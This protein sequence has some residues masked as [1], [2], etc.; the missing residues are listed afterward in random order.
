MSNL[1]S[2]YPVMLLAVNGTITK[3][4]TRSLYVIFIPDFLYRRSKTWEVT[5]TSG[6]FIGSPQQSSELH[7]HMV[8]LDYC[9]VCNVVQDD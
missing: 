9:Y 4:R 6:D 7:L 2:T 5:D 8:Y 1:S 3:F